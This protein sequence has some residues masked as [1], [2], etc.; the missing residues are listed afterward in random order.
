VS[1]L[2]PRGSERG[3]VAVIRRW[4]E[5]AVA[6][7]A[8]AAAVAV[9]AAPSA[10]ARDR[11]SA[12]PPTVTPDDIRFTDRTL[13]EG[14]P[15]DVG[16]LPGYIAELRTDAESYLKPTPDHPN[17]PAYPGGVLLAAKDG[18]VVANAAFGKAVRY[19]SVGPPPERTGVELPADQ[20]I[21]AQRDTIY[22]IASMSKLFTTIV[23]LQLV[24]RGL[25]DLDAPVAD[26][27]PEF[28]AAGK[29]DVTVRML[30]T[31]T[32]GLPP[33]PDPGLWTYDL[34]PQQRLAVA[35]ATPLARENTP[36][37]QYIYSD[38]GFMAL[39]ALV[40]AVTGLPLDEAVRQGITGPL[41]MTDTVYNP[42][43]DLRPR[44]AATEYE[45]YVDRGMVWGE[46]HDENAWALGG[47]AG[48]AGV[49]STAHD[50]A[51]LSQMLLNGGQY[52]GVRILREATV[53]EALVNYNARFMSKY[54]DSDRGLGFQ[55]S[56]YRYMGPLSSPVTFGHMGYTGTSV[57]VDPL[58]HSFVILLTNR[59]HP[60]RDWGGNTVVRQKLSSDL[61]YAKPVRPL[62]GGTAW[63]AERGKVKT[64]LTLTAP[65]LD[66]ARNATASFQFW[67]DTDPRGDKVRF[68]S[69][70][71]NGETWSPTAMTLSWAGDRW[72][73]DGVVEGYG[74]RHWWRVSADLPRGTTNIRW[75][76]RPQ[77]TEPGVN[78]QG[79]GVYVDKIRAD[80]ADVGQPVA[81]GWSKAKD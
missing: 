48:H 41:G 65:V 39:G 9:A 20:Q 26:Y 75:S 64:T 14:Q 42:S 68:E 61:A 36:G 29:E 74:G 17:Y 56:T 62:D 40:Q 45:P 12:G 71:D 35:L 6:V 16:L 38:I 73:A 37:G 5:S 59:V 8:V 77:G 46:V 7:C 13:R 4:V 31:H 24:E 81:D 2:T 78:A 63:R 67:Y 1:E 34:T 54:P 44:I 11:A 32:S 19:S 21:P 58:S 52:G 49:F 15:Q 55:L 79:R 28:A 25:V 22:D 23:V 43:P 70:T 47:V 33:D 72:T 10:F 50:L 18:V 53:R 30:L 51:I 66:P 27:V 76:Y 80:G 57:V 69:S 3:G 60:S